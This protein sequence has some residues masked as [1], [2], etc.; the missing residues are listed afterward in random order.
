MT[1][2]AF[3]AYVQQLLAPALNPHHQMPGLLCSAW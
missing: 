3:L 1:G 2:R